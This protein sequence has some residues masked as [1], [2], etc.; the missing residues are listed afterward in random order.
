M[1]VDAFYRTTVRP[2]LLPVRG[3][4]DFDFLTDVG[5]ENYG[6]ENCKIT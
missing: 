1:R 5:G 4:K 6:D 3:E 2:G